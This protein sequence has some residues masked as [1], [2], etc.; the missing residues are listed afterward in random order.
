MSI[1]FSPFRLR[2]IEFKNRIFLSP[3]CQYS[4]E[5]GMPTDWHLVHLGSHAVGG[6]SMVMVEATGVS[7]EGRIS[8]WDSGI[9][10]ERH[11]QAFK[12]ITTFI[13][14][15]GVV[16]GIQ[17]AH[18]GRKASTDVPWRGEKPLT[19]KEG[20]W[21]PLAPSPIP[22]GDTFPVP[23]EMTKEDLKEVISQFAAAARRSLKA[24]FKVI[25][26]HMAH[27]Y[28]L[29]EFL[30]PISNQR[31]DEYGGS[32]QDRARLPLSVAKAVRESWPSDL[33]LLVR[34][35]CTDWVDGGWDLAQSVELSHW[36]K[37]I[38]VD[39][40]DCSSGGLVP[41]AKIPVGPGY[42]TPF[43]A[44]IRSKVAIATGTVGLI[45]Q[46]VQAEQILATG[47]ADVVI[48][49]RELLRNPYWPLHAAKTLNV[50]VSWPPQYLRAK[51]R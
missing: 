39:L 7:P 10:S 9:W 17:L 19:K 15:Q 12:R 21:Q 27:G 1:L 48:I 36:L 35:S 32:L 47:Q 38:G 29:H 28:L 42:Q 8:P 45:T 23:R 22:F 18:A 3:M 24:G 20:G 50:D 2:D 37:D 26:I 6:V 16:P 43:A 13:E 46:P 25:E 41:H 14:G 5:E 33:P 11:V 49:A 30:S 40:I 44:E 31:T 51:L 34:I 4:S